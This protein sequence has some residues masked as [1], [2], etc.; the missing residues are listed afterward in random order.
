MAVARLVHPPASPCEA[1]RAGSSDPAL[2]RNTQNM[3]TNSDYQAK[4]S[5]KKFIWQFSFLILGKKR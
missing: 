5:I 3:T 1:L 2:F 4:I